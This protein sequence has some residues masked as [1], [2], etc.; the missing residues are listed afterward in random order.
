MIPASDERVAVDVIQTETVPNT[1]IDD[2]YAKFEAEQ[3]KREMIWRDNRA[4]KRAK[5]AEDYMP[6]TAA[7]PAEAS[8]RMT[9]DIP[10]STQATRSSEN[11]VA[12]QTTEVTSKPSEVDEVSL[13]KIQLAEKDR[14]CG[15]LTKQVEEL[16]EVSHLAVE[17]QQLMSENFL[18]VSANFAFCYCIIYSE[19]GGG[20]VNRLTDIKDCLQGFEQKY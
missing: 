5:I 11:S 17:R 1:S 19:R 12:T 20:G 8:P 13:L 10:A 9:E 16:Q 3:K 7:S 18:K 2:P 14:A 4:T 15:V 6:S